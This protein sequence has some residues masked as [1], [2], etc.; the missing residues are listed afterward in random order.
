MKTTDA[1]NETVSGKNLKLKFG[2]YNYDRTR[3]LSDGT[4]KIEGVDANFESA[5]VITEIFERMIKKQEFDVSELGMTYFL[6]VFDL[7]NC[8][9]IALPVFVNR[10]FRHSA[11][12]INTSKGINKPEDLAGKTIGEFALFSHDAG[13]WPKGILSDEYGVKAEQCRWIIGGLDWPMPPV[14]FV[15]KPY[16]K[17]VDVSE[18]PEGTDLGAMLEAGEID[19]LISADI[20]KCILKKSP[21]VTQLF[22]DSKSAE[23]DYF[24]RTGIFR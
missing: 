5:N 21:N 9:F 1:L 3:A 19:A 22:P 7:E 12:Y 16:P 15:P 24:K 8:P 18:A 11:I 17:N 20:P 4:V 23:Q 14:N 6:R 2:F 13:T 10:A